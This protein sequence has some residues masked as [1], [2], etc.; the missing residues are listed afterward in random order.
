MASKRR[1]EKYR[2]DLHDILQAQEN[3]VL[4]KVKA[5]LISVMNDKVAI[6]K[7]ILCYVHECV[8]KMDDASLKKSIY[9]FLLD[10]VHPRAYLFTREIVLVRFSLSELYSEENDL[11]EAARILQGF[12]F[13]R[14]KES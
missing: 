1:I 14:L 10:L 4:E 5:W 3:G 12:P 6:T 9:L 8:V 7:D 11:K 13:E 2:R